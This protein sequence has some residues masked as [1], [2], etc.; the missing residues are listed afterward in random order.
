MGKQHTIIIKL[1]NIR[2]TGDASILDDLG[3]CENRND[4]IF[5]SLIYILIYLLVDLLVID[6]LILTTD[7]F[8]DSLVGWLINLLIDS[9]I[10]WLTYPFA[11]D[12][13]TTVSPSFNPRRSCSVI[14]KIMVNIKNQINKS[15]VILCW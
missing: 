9:F 2:I 13:L 11:A 14:Q 10:N 7:W 5:N 6:W 4:N 15:N 8:I 1:N 3:D 12:H